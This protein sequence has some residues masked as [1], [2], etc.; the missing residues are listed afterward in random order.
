MEDFL[1]RLRTGT[2]EE[3]LSMKDVHTVGVNGIQCNEYKL[4]Q[5][6]KKTIQD[7]ILKLIYEYY[8]N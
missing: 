7:E 8:F 3:D 6:Q 5:F 4:K 2:Y 1:S